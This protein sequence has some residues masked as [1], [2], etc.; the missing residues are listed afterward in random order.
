VH[1]TS[2]SDRAQNIF[3]HNATNYSLGLL[4][5]HTF[6]GSM[7]NEARVDMAGW[8][9]NELK[10][11]PQAPLGLP[12]ANMNHFDGS[13]SFSNINPTGFGPSI[14][15]IFDQWTYNAKDVLTK[16]YKSHSLKFGGQYT[17]LAQL[18]SATWAASENFYF[19]NYWDFLNDAP[20]AET[21]N[22]ANP[23]TGAPTDSRKDDR[24]FIPSFFV[25]DDWKVRPNLTI[26]LGLR[27][28]YFSGM[29]EKKG[30]NPRLNIGRGPS[31]FTSLAIVLKQPQ[32]DAQKGNF[33]PEVGFA[34]S[35]SR[36][37]GKLVLRGGFGMSFNGLEQ[38]ITTNTRFDPPFLTNATKLPLTGD[39]IIYGINSIYQYGS[40][41][42]NP[43]LISTFNSAN[44]P[45]SGIAIAITGIDNKLKTTYVYRYSLEG[46][47]DLGHQ[48]VATLGYTGSSGRHLPLQYN[49]YNKYAAQI[50][51]GS[52]AFNPAVNFIDWYEDTGTS[53]FNSMLAEVRHQFAHT[54]EA[55]V[56]YR[57]AKSLDS[58]SGPYTQSDYQFLPGFNWGPSDFDSRNMIKMFAMWTPTLFHSNSWAEKVAGGWTLSPIFNFHSGFPWNPHYGGIGCNAFYPGAG[59][60]DLRPASYLGGASVSQ[61]NDTFKT[62]RCQQLWARWNAEGPG[63]MEQHIDGSH[64]LGTSRYPRDWSERLCRASLFRS[65]S[66]SNQGLRSAEYEGPWRKRS[67]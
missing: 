28:E 67:H 52:A 19:N 47:Y 34:W 23:L 17:R 45:D 61:S 7:L 10:D 22:G 57:W 13:N 5:N 16:V 11:N 29:T 3:H 37:A 62:R 44:L 51:N 48:W 6:S 21:V 49:L 58:G 56:Q 41:T 1:N 38:A 12:F 26:N 32:V 59:D 66:R 53:S 15:S 24:Q 40:L 9:W 18:D 8:K 64:T 36:D 43:A 30:N 35:P 50:L 20:Q 46:Q 33:G 65:R 54:F 27:W 63:R 14:G 2:F 25:Q 39:Q 4:Y 60:C 42:P 55:D 31:T